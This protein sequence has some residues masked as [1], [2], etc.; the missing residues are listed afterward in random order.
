MNNMEEVKLP[1]ETIKNGNTTI[2][3][4]VEDVYRLINRLD[5]VLY[6]FENKSN[7]ILNSI[8]KNYKDYE[9]EL[10]IGKGV[11]KPCNGDIY[12]EQI[13]ETVAFVKAKLN[14]NIKKRRIIDRLIKTLDK[15]KNEIKAEGTKLDN[16]IRMDEETLSNF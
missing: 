14:A 6:K 9:G 7:E 10:I 8:H 2:K 15:A 1:I 13:G 16:Y 4:C 3:V 11:S 12:D 5:N